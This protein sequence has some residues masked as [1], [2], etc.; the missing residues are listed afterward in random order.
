MHI[1][2]KFLAAELV[3]LT[4][5]GQP[6]WAERVAPRV[7]RTQLSESLAPTEISRP[8]QDMSGAVYGFVAD[9]PSI[10]AKF[11]LA[12]SGRDPV[13][14]IDGVSQ[15]RQSLCVRIRRAQGGY[16]ADFGATAPKGRGRVK[17][18]FDS[19][20]EARSWLHRAD[21]TGMEM[22]VRA[23]EAQRGRCNSKAP[24]LPVSWSHDPTQRYTLLV[25]GG[26]TGAPATR[27]AG[28]RLQN[29]SPLSQTLRRSDLGAGVYNYS[30]PLEL[31]ERE[32]GAVVSVR[33]IW[34]Q[35]ARRTGQADVGVKP[36]CQP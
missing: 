23:T 19:T 16:R 36:P 13:F 5:I 25:G 7:A 33:V 14:F 10:K 34:F 11:P 35:G 29:C 28:G 26:A 24:L 22:A 30:C 2:F 12:S 18:A 20:P 21:P 15:R 3:G 8:V 6:A 31:S 1:V 9:S 27:V 32:C 17:V 4:A